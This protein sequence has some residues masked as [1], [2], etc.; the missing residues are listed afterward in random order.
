MASCSPGAASP[1]GTSVAGRAS[2]A[3]RAAGRAI[4]L[5]GEALGL[6]RVPRGLPRR[7]LELPAR[8]ALRVLGA[9]A[10]RGRRGLGDPGRLERRTRLRL[11]RSRPPS[12]R[13]PR[14]RPR[15]AR[16][17][18]S[19]ASRSASARRSRG[20]SPRPT[21][22]VNASTTALPSRVTASQPTGSDGLHLEG[23]REVRRPDG[24]GQQRSHGAV[25]DPGARPRPGAPPAAVAS[26]SSSR[27]SSPAVPPPGTFSAAARRSRTTTCPR[28]PASV[29]RTAPL[30]DVGAGELAQRRLD[31]GAQRRLDPEVLVHPPAAELARGAGDPAIL[32]LGQAAARAAPGAR[33]PRRAST[34][35]GPLVPPRRGGCPRPRPPPHAPPRARRPPPPPPPQPPPAPCGPRPG[36]AP[37]AARRLSASA[38]R[39]RSSAVR[40][41]ASAWRRRAVSA[42]AARAASA[43]RSAASSSPR[44]R[45][46]ARSEPSSVERLARATGRRRPARPPAPG[47]ARAPA[48]PGCAA[49]AATSA[50]AA[51]R[52]SAIRCRS[53][54]A[55]A[56]SPVARA[57][58][59]PSAVR[60]ARA[61]SCT[62]RRSR[63]CSARSAIEV[64]MPATDDSAASSASSD[65]SVSARRASRRR[66]ASAARPAASCQRPCAAAISAAASSS[67]AVE[68]GRLLLGLLAEPAG[69]RP[70][71]GEDVLDAGEVRLGLGELLLGLAAAALVAPD[72]GDLLEQRPALLGPQ[73]E[74]LVDHALADEQE[75]VLGEV[76][77]V[78]QVDEVAQADPLLVEQVVV[79]AGAV[80]APAELDHVVLD[81]QQ[82]VGVV[83]DEGDVGHALGAALLGAGPD[84][85]LALADPERAALLAERPAE[86]VGQVA[87]ARAVGP[88]DRADAGPELDERP[89]GERLEALDAQGQEAGRR[90]HEPLVVSG[91]GA[92]RAAARRCAPGAARAGLPF[93]LAAPRAPR[94]RPPSRRCA[95]TGPRRR[96]S[97]RPSTTTSMRN[98]FSWS[99]PDRLEQPV[100]RPLARRPLGVLLEPA[101]G[102]LERGQ[103][104]VGGELRA[105]PSAWSQSRAASQPR[106]R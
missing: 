54:A 51:A 27:R 106:S 45:D 6:G 66:S 15:P 102:A 100:L 25:R 14:R 76:R 7:R 17:S 38:A 84:D 68:P 47:P 50:S 24:A 71:L 26:A 28:S 80:E 78:E 67:P 56:I 95:A 74:R 87:L 8:G 91:S 33:E 62:T 93:A 79:L 105:P 65:R 98:C 59:S 57:S 34:R 88:D 75:R 70:E 46:A 97:T 73:R 5:E 30:H 69:L 55:A 90:A 19:R 92:G 48:P 1:V 10:P 21:R 53:R 3:A 60:S 103:R 42:S 31:R 44:A 99:G 81:R 22:T 82:P 72:P 20:E 40:R 2:S 32:L 77:R 94:R 29:G 49:A 104:R 39:A 35:P 23:G 52:S 9:P 11:P 13:A 89:L 4:R 63:S 86:G 36:S 18:A 85:V 83:E 37:A 61:A 41:S 16:A 96:P 101:L 64:A 58:R 43:R 12:S